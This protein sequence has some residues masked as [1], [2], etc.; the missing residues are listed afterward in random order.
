MG[1]AEGDHGARLSAHHRDAS[2]KSV[3]CLGDFGLGR[4]LTPAAGP[5]GELPGA[6]LYAD[7]LWSGLWLHSPLAGIA[8][9]SLSVR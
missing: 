1:G 5:P 8:S 7:Q 3:T 4:V 2:R 9:P 6:L